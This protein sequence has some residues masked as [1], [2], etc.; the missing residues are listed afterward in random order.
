MKK[1]IRRYALENAVRY[2]KPPRVDAVL[3]RVLGEHPELRKDARRVARLVADEIKDIESKGLDEWNAELRLI[4]PE[5][6]G[7]STKRESREETKLPE[8]PLSGHDKKVVMRFAPNPNGAATLGSARGIVINSEYAKMYKG[9]FI[10]RF[11]DTDPLLKRPMLEAYEWYIEDCEWLDATPDEVIVA[12]ERMDLYYRYGKELIERGMAYVCLCTQ[13]EFKVYKERMRACPHRTADV[14]TNMENW[15]RM[16]SGFYEEKEAVLRIKTDM[17]NED[18]A[19]RDWVAFRILKREHPRVGMRYIVWPTL[20]FE[21]GIED[22]LLGI[23]HI[24]RGKDLMKSEKRQRFLYDYLGWQYPVTTLWGKIKVYEFGKFSTSELRKGIERGEYDGWDDPKLPTLR[25]LRRRGFQPEAIRNFFIAMGVS[26][27]DI[28]VSMK[29]LYAENRKIVDARAMRYFFV[30]RPVEMI[31]K[32]GKSKTF[33]AR[34]L[35]H[36]SR[37]DYREIRTGNRVYV[38][39]ADFE[40]LRKGQRIR[41]KY[42][43]TVE[44]EDTMPL[45]AR[46]IEDKG[47][48]GEERG[49][50]GEDMIIHWAPDNGIRVRVRKPEC[51]EEGIGEPLIA[52]ELG[53]VVQFERYGF[54]RI[55]SVSDSVVVA[56]FT[57]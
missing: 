8:L 10:L 55:D 43:C 33:V 6:T 32:N 47:E 36:P 46:I 16:L 4:A 28:S 30:H 53:N 37:S 27:N 2:G 41:L 49:G 1:E 20:D 19:L 15:D 31:L 42:L 21:S 23:T 11:D 17:A 54:V 39:G 29:N 45:V 38:S 5:M 12:S 3:K 40:K 9:K 44:I 7:T 57:H 51:I 25:A 35:K 50:G 14:E 13:E 24:L 48:G 26:Q 52:S 18:P 34:A 22:H 56:Y